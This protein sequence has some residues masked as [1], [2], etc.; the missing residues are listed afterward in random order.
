[1]QWKFNPKR[2][3]RVIQPYEDFSNSA[4]AAETFNAFDRTY[5]GTKILDSL[6]GD[7]RVVFSR[8]PMGDCYG[9][10]IPKKSNLADVK[11]C[12]NA[13]ALIVI[14]SED[15]DKAF[16]PF[17]LGHEGFHSIQDRRKNSGIVPMFNNKV[18]YNASL[19]QIGKEEDFIRGFKTMERSC[20]VV[21]ITIVWEMRQRG[22][23]GN[24]FAELL[25]NPHTAEIAS[26]ISDAGEWAAEQ[27]GYTQE[28]VINHC[29][30]W[31][32]I[33]G[34]YSVAY[35][36]YLDNAAQQTYRD[37][38]KHFRFQTLPSLP[39]ADRIEFQHFALMSDSFLRESPS[40]AN[41]FPEIERFAMDRQARMIEEKAMKV[42]QALDW[43]KNERP[44]AFA[45]A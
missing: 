5:L 32:N 6:G 39:V 41:R 35:N 28:Q 21:A 43:L 4:F 18:L 31:G 29:L 34:L 40:I 7:K 30:L 24:L 45:A 26:F 15:V 3:S 23:S 2:K 13:D 36:Q 44:R 19:F 17:I 8:E 11:G 1:M 20:D 33:G 12:D 14:D 10:Y 22:L 38:Q 9:Q 25:N 27:P 42:R 37:T 16:L